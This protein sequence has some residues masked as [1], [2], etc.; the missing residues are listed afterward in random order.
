[1]QLREAQQRFAEWLAEARGFSGHTLRA[2]AGDVRLFAQYVGPSLQVSEMTSGAI[3]SFFA[4]QR[5]AGNAPSSLR[6]RAAS[7][8]VFASWLVA[9]GHLASDPWNEIT[10][11]LPRKRHLPRALPTADVRQLILEGCVASGRPWTA[12][13]G[14]GFKSAYEATTLTAAVVMLVTGL[15]VSGCVGIQVPDMDLESGTIRVF[16]KGARERNV[17][18]PDQWTTDLVVAYLQ[19]RLRVNPTHPYLFFNCHGNS[20]S[21]SAL[22]ARVAQL[23][24]R[25]GVTRRV[26]PHM[27]RHS[28]ATE[29]LEAGVDI[30]YVQRLLGHASL[31]TTEIYTHVAD[32]ALRRMLV[33]ARVIDRCLSR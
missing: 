16:G 5:V 14:E 28:A 17:Y 7:L 31:S 20:L 21:E 2:Y 22:R 18:L 32:V 4:H 29:L 19:I 11:E 13:S 9:A 25:A 23:A 27:L 30:R 24:S 12:P 6:R 8:R 10:L 15:R 3:A 33:E 26:T 1:V